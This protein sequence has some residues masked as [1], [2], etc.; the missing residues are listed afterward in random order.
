MRKL[1]AI[2]LVALS[3]T[4]CASVQRAASYNDGNLTA[5]AQITV[6]GKR[7]NVSMHPV[8]SSLLAQTTLADA[9]GSGFIK[10]LTFGLAR[11]FRPDPWAVE[12]AMRDFVRP[13]GCEITAVRQIGAEQVSFEGDY[14]C[15]AGVDL[16]AT[17][18]A[19]TARLMRGEPI[20]P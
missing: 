19:Q 8:D 14:T 16:R 13:L 1:A 4:G 5:D 17:V 2:A 11:G 6:Q 20:Q 10:G 3:L 7:M 12:A 9:A 18:R 15:P